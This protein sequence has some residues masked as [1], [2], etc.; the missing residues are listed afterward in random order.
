MSL[1]D[2]LLGRPLASTEER[3]EKIGTLA[4]IPIFG[5]DALGSA[6]YGPEAALTVLIPI[7]ILEVSYIVPISATVIVLLTIVYFSYRQ[8]KRVRL[9][10]R[11]G[12][13][14]GSYTC[15]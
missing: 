15:R 11:H 3:A 5:L 4:G 14:D 7:G 2:V 6:A 12:R 1:I 9:Q 8:R 10:L 13:N